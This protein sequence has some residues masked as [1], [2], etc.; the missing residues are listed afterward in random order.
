MTHLISTELVQK[1]KGRANVMKKGNPSNPL[2]ESRKDSI[3]AENDLTSRKSS[4]LLSKSKEEGISM[5]DPEWE[6]IRLGLPIKRIAYWDLLNTIALVQKDR[7][8]LTNMVEEIYIPV[9]E[10]RHV[11]WNCV[12][13]SMRRAVQSIWQKGNRR[14]LQRIMHRVLP[15]PPTVGEFLGAFVV[16]LESDNIVPEKTAK[17]TVTYQP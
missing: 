9:A 10:M 16:Y 11:E 14:L 15:E 6:L 5:R 2:E 12:E 3:S 4:I 17:E 13:V 8:R 1:W 7:F